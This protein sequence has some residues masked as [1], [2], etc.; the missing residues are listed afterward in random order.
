LREAAYSEVV[1]GERQHLHRRFAEAMEA[2]KTEGRIDV[3]EASSEL[4][5]HWYKGG[6]SR[7]GLGASLAAA[8]AALAARGFGSAEDH[9]ERALQLWDAVPDAR[10]LTGLDHAE[11]LAR[12]AQAAHMGGDDEQAISLITQA[13]EET[14][15]ESD[16]ATAAHLNDRLGWYQF[17]SGAAS[18]ALNA[19]E[20]ALSLSRGHGSQAEAGMLANAGLSTVSRNSP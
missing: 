10:Q 3:T 7:R 18:A 4:A 6:D 2:A 11:V 20:L 13:L 12:A 1:P 19:Y 15:A 5:F 16:R 17:K 14:D 9:Y 8:E